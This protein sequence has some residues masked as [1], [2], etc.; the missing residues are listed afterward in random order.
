MATWDNIKIRLG[1]KL[2]DPDLLIYGGMLKD[3]F[4]AEYLKYAAKAPTEQIYLL[5]TVVE[6]DLTDKQGD[7]AIPSSVLFI[8]VT[9]PF[10][11]GGLISSDSRSFKRFMN[12]S[13]TKYS[14]AMRNPNLTPN[15]DEVYWLRD[16][17]K[18]LFLSDNVRINFSLNYL[19]ELDF[20][21]TDYIAEEVI[22]I[23]MNMVV[24]TILGK[25]QNEY[26]KTD[27]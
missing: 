3:C 13:P 21:H 6:L 17:N 22:G 11:S 2:G 26:T 27:K 4:R 14:L 24:N 8:N 5:Q 7:Y 25:K 9:A 20:D 1:D 12:V 23:I 18:L 15:S 10:L 19:P 16:G